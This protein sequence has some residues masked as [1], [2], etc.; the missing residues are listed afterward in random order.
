MSVPG[1][2]P[3]QYSPSIDA[4]LVR[5]ARDLGPL[6]A[7]ASPTISAEAYGRALLGIQEQMTPVI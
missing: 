4:G 6:I 5:R 1:D 7:I 2:F 3:L